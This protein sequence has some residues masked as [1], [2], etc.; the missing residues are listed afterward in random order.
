M[1]N[2]R[3]FIVRCSS[4]D[5]ETLVRHAAALGYA[6]PTARVARPGVARYLVDRGLGGG[7]ILCEEDRTTLGRILWDV[8]A[9][10]AELIRIAE[11][12]S[13]PSAIARD[14]V[15]T[16]ADQID[17]ALGRLRHLFEP[18]VSR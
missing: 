4:S 11:G 17:H 12:A 8:R 6:S 16:A 9:A 2:R 15:T 3:S 1:T 10:K 14:A 7:Q 13:D 5:Y 18:E